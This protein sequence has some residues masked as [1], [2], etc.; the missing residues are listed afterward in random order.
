M[1]P[2]ALNVLFTYLKGLRVQGTDTPVFHPAGHSALC[3]R[4]EGY[5]ETQGITVEKAFAFVEKKRA[6]QLARG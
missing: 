1:Q 2:T 3:R 6:S 4:I 5:I